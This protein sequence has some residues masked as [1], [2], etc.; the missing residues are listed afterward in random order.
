M[1]KSHIDSV[2]HNAASVLASYAN[3]GLIESDGLQQLLNVFITDELAVTQ[4]LFD[5]FDL[6][7]MGHNRALPFCKGKNE[8]ESNNQLGRYFT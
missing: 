7:E 6:G 2:C 5:T 3:V 4:R 1:I 8:D